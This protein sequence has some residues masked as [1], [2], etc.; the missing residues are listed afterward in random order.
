[1]LR[2]ALNFRSPP[3]LN[4]DQNPA[5]IGTVVRTRGMDDLLRH[6]SIIEWFFQKT[7]IKR[8]ES[9]FHAEVS[10]CARTWSDCGN[11]VREEIGRLNVSYNAAA[12][13]EAYPAIAIDGRGDL[14]C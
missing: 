2:I 10:I 13:P 8:G 3:V 6:R 9:A 1:M 11:T 12:F 14:V 7:V 5:R 4:R